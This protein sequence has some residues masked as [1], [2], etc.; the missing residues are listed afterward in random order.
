MSKRASAAIAA[1]TAAAIGG[2]VALFPGQKP[3]H[4]DVALAAEAL[5]KPWEGRSLRA[6]LDTLPTKPVWT[7]CDGDTQNVKPGMVETPEGCDRRLVTR[8]ESEFRPALVACIAG[9]ADK[10]LS[11]RTMMLSLAWNI[12]EARAC[13]SSAARL[14]RA[15]RYVESCRA[16]TAWNKAGGRVLIG[17]KRRREFGDETRM[18]EHELCREGL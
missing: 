8:M 9:W 16:A 3:V 4:D 2:M 15:G 11:W 7:I 12:G 17:L 14:G 13:A 5:V 6:Y 1:V 10:P 18:G